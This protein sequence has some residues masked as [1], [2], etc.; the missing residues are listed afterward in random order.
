MTNKTDF[1]LCLAYRNGGNIASDALDELFRRH[2][3]YIRKTA[4][5]HLHNIQYN[6]DLGDD[7]SDTSRKKGELLHDACSEAFIAA[8]IA[9][10]HYDGHSS[11]LSTFLSQNIW[12]RFMDLKRG[13]TKHSQ[14]ET[15]LS[16]FETES[17]DGYRTAEYVEFDECS[18]RSDDDRHQAACREG[19]GYIMSRLSGRRQECFIAILEGARQGAKNLA[20][21]AAQK[22]GC[23][24]VTIYNLIH[25][26]AGEFPDGLS[27]WL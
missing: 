3:S 13:N 21:Y 1:E 12:S 23:S 27:A 9:F 8:E 24:R 11:S 10:R 5:Y 16:S 7:N 17:D 6:S 2:G 22:L 25:A 20:D 18:R 26:I 14:R 15:V 19:V 4:S